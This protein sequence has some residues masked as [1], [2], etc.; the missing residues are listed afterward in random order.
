MFFKKKKKEFSLYDE[1]MEYI[2]EEEELEEEEYEEDVLR[3]N[4]IQNVKETEASEDSSVE[5]DET[6][7]EENAKEEKLTWSQ[8]RAARK[9]EKEAKKAAR[10]ERKAKHDKKKYS[11]PP[12]EP[13]R[14]LPTEGTIPAGE[15]GAAE[16]PAAAA[17][18]VEAKKPAAA[19]ETASAT[20]PVNG[21]LSGEENLSAE[22]SLIL[23]AEERKIPKKKIFIIAGLSCLILL[24][25]ITFI[26]RN[27][28]GSGEDP[29][30]VQSVK[31]ITELGS[32]NGL[33]NR[34]TGVVDTQESWNITL[35]G[36]MSVETCYVKVGDQVKKGDKLFKYNTEE[37]SLNKQKKELE[38]DTAKNEITQ[39]NSEIKG[40]Q[41]DLKNAGT[42]E[43]IELQSQILQAQATVKKDEYAIKSAQKELDKINKNIKDATVKSKMTGLVKK[44]NTSLGQ[45]SGGE[46][47]DENVP[48]ADEGTDNSTYMTI[49][50][51]GDYRIVGKVSETNISNLSEGDPMIVRSRVDDTKTWKGV[52]DKIKTDETAQGSTEETA[53]DYDEYGGASGEKASTYNFYVSLDNDEG[54]MMGQHVLIEVDNNQDEHKDGIWLPSTFLEEKQGSYYVWVEGRGKKLDRRKVTIGETDENSD[55][56]QITDGLKKSDY[57]AEALDDLS[58]GRKTTHSSA[59]A[60]TSDGMDDANM[61]EEVLDQE[62][63]EEAPDD[64]LED[65]QEVDAGDGGV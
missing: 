53:E 1:D 19:G 23:N 30:Y 16:I 13:V 14:A 45:A 48:A 9:A 43:K 34:Y 32:G 31:D 38:I 5:P 64:S 2:R 17:E 59:E 57:I 65:L 20:E 58:E 27:I 29:V 49:I 63:G 3:Q 21:S 61:D 55:L 8:R 15:A 6:A 7:M 36:D 46:E 12:A 40:Y 22:E 51:I 42:S 41:A 37:L 33:N 62:G 4:E 11:D 26:I 56:I 10:L 47:S 28:G 39:M 60:N 25:A 18:P 52:I 50:A 54:L 44:I 35:D 24:I